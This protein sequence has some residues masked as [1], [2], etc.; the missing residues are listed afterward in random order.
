MKEDQPLWRQ[1][2]LRGEL[3]KFE[4]E[5]SIHSLM[6]LLGYRGKRGLPVGRERVSR[7]VRISK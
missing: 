6:P 5:L 3:I 1:L 7:E 2:V 4:A